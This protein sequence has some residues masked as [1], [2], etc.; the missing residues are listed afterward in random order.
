MSFGLLRNRNCE[1]KLA[2]TSILPVIML[3]DGANEL[4]HYTYIYV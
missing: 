2:L 1:K 4:Y 3:D